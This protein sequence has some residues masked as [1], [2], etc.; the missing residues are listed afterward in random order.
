MQDWARGNQVF[1]PP[2]N[3]TTT[4]TCKTGPGETKSSAHR[5]TPLPLSHARLGPGKPSLQPTGE[6]HYHSHMQDWARGNQVFS[7][8]ENTTTTLTCKTGPGETKSSAH[9]RTPLPLSHA[10]LGPGK[11]SLQPTGEHHYHSHMQDWA[12]GNQVFSPPENTTTTLTCK[13]GPG[14]T[15]APENTTTTLTCKTG[16]GETKSSAHRRTPLPLSHARL[17]P[18][19]PSLQPTGEHHYHSHMQ[20]WARGNQSTGEHHYHSHMQDWARGNQVFSPPENTTTTLTCKTG[21]G[22]TKSGEHH[23]HS[24]MQ[25]WARENQVRRTPLPLSHAR[26]G[27]GKPKHRRTPLP[28]SHAR[29]GPGK[30]SLQPTGEHHYHSHMQDWA[31]GN[32]VRRTPLPLLHARLGPGKP[33]PENTTTTLTCK[34]GPGETK[35]GEHHYHSH[36]QDWARGNQVFSPPEN[37]T[38]TLTCKT[39]PGETKS[40]AHRRTPLPLSHAR[41]GPGKPKHRR[42]PLPLSHARLGPGKPSLQP[43]GEHHYHSHMQDWAR[44][45][46]VFSPPENTTTTLTC[47]TGPGETKAPENTTTTLTCKTGPGETKSSA[48]RRTPLPLSHARLG[49]GKPSPENTTTTLTC[50]TGPGK[51]KSGEHHY[52][53]HMQDWARGNQST[54]EHHYH[55]HMQDWARGNQVFSPPENTTTTLTCKTGPGETKSGEHHYHSYMQDWAR[56]NQVRRTPLPLSHARLGPGKPSPENTTT[57]LTC[58]TGPGET[59]SGEHHYHSHMQDWARGNQVRRTPLPLSHARLGPGKP[60]PE[61]TTTTLTCKTGPGETKSG[62]HHYHSHMQDWARGNQVRRTPLPLSHARLG[63]GKPSPENTTTT[64]TCKTGPGETKAPENTTT[65]LTCKTGPGE[66]K[67]SAH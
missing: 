8:P 6:H 14:E 29:L 36:M 21:P 67:S 38:T 4:L 49:P 48:H 43:T 13:T 66:T 27:P 11:P 59:K 52:H 1:S 64:L 2:E 56:G 9:R 63:P 19:K 40:S 58:K 23:Y 30:P 28:L 16:P 12:R 65:T 45:N 44:G 61:N 62:E 41:L 51:T 33:S 42:T 26:L 3:T 55:S 10:R 17:G 5:R 53:S 37:T 57:T 24:H 39:G 50:K 18:G 34:T 35:S 20:D 60:S 46:Q 54:G 25:D 22:E 47:K 15:K 32:Q 7:P 31:R